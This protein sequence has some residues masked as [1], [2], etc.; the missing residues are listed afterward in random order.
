MMGGGGKRGAVV[1]GRLV[2]RIFDCHRASRS[3]FAK[4]RR[5]QGNRNK[6]LTPNQV[7]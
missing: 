6:R 1:D 7:Y 4:G 5:G 2:G 3:I